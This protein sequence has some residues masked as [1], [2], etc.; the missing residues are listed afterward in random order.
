[1]K[2]SQLCHYY[3]QSL[4]LSRA[5]THRAIQPSETNL[6]TKFN[7]T[8]QALLGWRLNINSRMC[9]NRL[10]VRQRNRLTWKLSVVSDKQW[11]DHSGLSAQNP[12]PSADWEEKEK[13]LVNLSEVSI[14]QKPSMMSE[15][16][17]RHQLS[18]LDLVNTHTA[19]SML[20]R[21]RGRLNEAKQQH[22]KC[23]NMQISRIYFTASFF[24]FFSLI[25]RRAAVC[26]REFQLAT[27]AA[28]LQNGDTTSST[29]RGEE[30]RK[31]ESE[32]LGKRWKIKIFMRK[33]GK[34][35]D[36]LS[37]LT[38]FDFEFFPINL[39]SVFCWRIWSSNNADD[40]N[41]RLDGSIDDF[42]CKNW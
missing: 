22:D 12:S 42:S 4:T 38:Q 37:K 23:V 40:E 16:L 39:L 15:M 28:N 10:G 35:T 26:W 1:M 41:V 13:S 36:F 21:E 17:C 32:R 3:I 29:V 5:T 14:S 8:L 9:E 33:L 2:N 24:V 25:R 11:L 6:L 30:G 27:C 19:H 18:T 34:V 20:S 7:K 31:S